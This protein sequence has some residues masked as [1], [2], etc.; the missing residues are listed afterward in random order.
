MEK[1]VFI[2]GD[3]YAD[4]AG[5]P[6]YVWHRRLSDIFSNTRNFALSGTGPQY[7]FSLFYK[8]MTDFKKDDIII[9]LLSDPFRIHWPEHALFSGELSA[10]QW[11]GETKE[12]ECVFNDYP[13][14]LKNSKH[15]K[16]INYYNEHKKEMDFFYKTY[17]KELE[18]SNEKNISFLYT[19]SQTLNLKLIVF[20]IFEM[21]YA[22]IARTKLSQQLNN[23]INFHLCDQYL[24]TISTNEIYKEELHKTKTNL[25]QGDKRRNHLSP[26]N[27]DIMFEYILS[28]I[29]NKCYFSPEFKQHFLYFDEVYQENVHLKNNPIQYIYE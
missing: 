17:M 21:R 15:I 10:I 5:T 18:V 26:E 19:I 22:Q 20:D 6:N 13:E 3:S 27:H 16:I 25:R 28:V 2:F 11:N 24:S 12:T 9:F 4:P 8:N 1:K 23:N 7:A 29:D 14:N